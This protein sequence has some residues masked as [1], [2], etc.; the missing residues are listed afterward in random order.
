MAPSGEVTATM[1]ETGEWDSG[2]GFKE[3]P[4]RKGSSLYGVLG[5]DS[6]PSKAVEELTVFRL[7]REG[8]G[9]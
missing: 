4:D 5:V 8:I 7:G 2:V 9:T 1:G 3:R 6:S